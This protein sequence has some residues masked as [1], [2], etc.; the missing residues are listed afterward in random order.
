MAVQVLQSAG[1]AARCEP[2][3]ILGTGHDEPAHLGNARPCCLSV[4]E[5]GSSASAIRYLLRRIQRLMPNAAIV[6][7]LWHA[8][9]TS[10]LLDALRQR[11]AWIGVG[12]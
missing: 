7:C 10:P 1:F 2:N 3:S 8:A 6:V 9:G 5:Q 12:A 11:G 4:L